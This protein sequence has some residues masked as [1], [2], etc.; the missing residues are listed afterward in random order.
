MLRRLI[1]NTPNPVIYEFCR[2]AWEK[3]RRE[4]DLP[5]PGLPALVPEYAEV[6]AAKRLFRALWSMFASRKPAAQSLR[7]RKAQQSAA[8]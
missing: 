2:N 7:R 4:E 8:G 6:G 3:Y 1:I 5:A